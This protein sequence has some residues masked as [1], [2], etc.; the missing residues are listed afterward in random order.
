MRTLP[1][2]SILPINIVCHVLKGCGG[3]S[4]PAGEVTV[5]VDGD[6]REYIVRHLAL[7]D[8]VDGSLV[9]VAYLVGWSPETASGKEILVAHHIREGGLFIIGAIGAGIHVTIARKGYRHHRRIET[10]AELII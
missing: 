7:S 1:D 5:Q 9:D 4:C 2:A 10:A 6:I 8:D 3:I